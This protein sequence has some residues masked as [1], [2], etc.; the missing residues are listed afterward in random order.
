MDLKSCRDQNGTCHWSAIRVA[1]AGSAECKRF[2]ALTLDMAFLQTLAVT[3]QA[4]FCG[5]DPMGFEEETI[6]AAKVMTMAIEMMAAHSWSTTQF[7]MTLPHS[8]A[9]GLHPDPQIATA[10][11][12]DRA[13]DWELILN[14]ENVV[15]QVAPIPA[16]VPMP[17]NEG[18]QTRQASVGHGPYQQCAK[19]LD[20]LD[21]HKHQLVR[22]VC[23]A[24][25]SAMDGAPAW[26]PAHP[27]GQE[28]LRYMFGNISNTKTFLEDTFR[29]VRDMLKRSG[30]TTSRF[31]RQ[32]HVLVSGLRRAKE[33]LL[34]IVELPDSAFVDGHC[35]KAKITDAVFTPPSNPQK[36]A[37]AM[38][39]GR[40]FDVGVP[41]RLPNGQVLEPLIDLTQLLGSSVAQASK[42]SN[43][44]G[45]VAGSGKAVDAA[46]HAEGDPAITRD[47]ADHVI[48]RAAGTTAKHRSSAA[49]A[50]IRGLGHVPSC[51]W[52][53][54]VLQAWRGCLLGKGLLYKLQ[55]RPPLVPTVFVSLGFQAYA[56][57]C[58]RVELVFAHGHE[59]CSL[60][61]PSN[62]PLFWVHGH[63]LTDFAVCCGLAT[64]LVVPAL[65]P[66]AMP[67][68]GLLW[69]ISEEVDIVRF[70]FQNKVILTTQHL[71]FL[72][73]AMNIRNGK[74][75]GKTNP[76]DQACAIA[77]AIIEQ[78]FPAMEE[79]DRIVLAQAIV[80]PD[81]AAGV[82]DPVLD[83]VL[84]ELQDQDRSY[85]KFEEL[86]EQVKGHKAM[87][88]VLK[89]N[90]SRVGQVR[91]PSLQLTPMEYRADILNS[92]YL[93]EKQGAGLRVCEVCE[94]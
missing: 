60:V 84:E 39:T 78:V 41:I 62:M 5:Q 69:R 77:K 46:V 54:C 53:G 24:M 83:Q 38:E 92:T 7:W 4:N 1:Q 20:Q 64:T 59:W 32:H 14:F 27:E 13:N 91:G 72:A 9:I 71:S 8:L 18:S 23:F 52:E 93:C 12:L 35:N 63:D 51:E 75:I 34:P 57:L 28:V 31:L 66:L 30:Q 33:H 25:S 50:L 29:D 61:S 55:R 70:A 68:Q 22:E 86:H 36:G 94:E 16:M 42:R 67:K 90:K 40:P 89:D 6:M 2:A 45:A 48:H 80:Q 26:S 65:Q 11:L 19:L 56:V 74:L 76:K 85:A 3:T 49:M 88:K 73:K 58:W 82:D 47:M 43:K 87:Q 17:G 10:G 37:L 79:D 81:I 15:L 44:A 21:F